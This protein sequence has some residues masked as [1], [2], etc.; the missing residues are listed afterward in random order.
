VRHEIEF[1]EEA[2]MELRALRSFDQA[3]ILDAIEDS[4]RFEPT[5]VS[6]HRKPVVPTELLEEFGITWELRVGD[7]R[8]FYDVVPTALVV[9]IRIVRKGRQ[10]TEGNLT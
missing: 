1:T 4:L 3:A 9:I 2:E 6:R 10:N 5:R 8:V 7:Y